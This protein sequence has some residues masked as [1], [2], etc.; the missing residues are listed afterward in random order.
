[1]N[2]KSTSRLAFLAAILGSSVA[3]NAIMTLNFTNVFAGDTPIGNNPWATLT[4]QND[5]SEVKT[6]H[7]Q[8]VTLDKVKFTLS[9]SASSDSTEY[10]TSLFL[11]MSSMPANFSTDTPWTPGIETGSASSGS[12]AFNNNGEKFDYKVNFKSSGSGQ[13]NPG[14]TVSW[15]AKG[16]GLDESM[17]QTSAKP[18]GNKPD[19]IVALL[20]VNHIKIS[21]KPGDGGDDEHDHNFNND[22]RFTG[23]DG[24]DKEHCYGDGHGNGKGNNDGGDCGQGVGSSTLFTSAAAVPEPSSMVAILIGG[25][26]ALRRRKK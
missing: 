15:D 5:G 23:L 13:V 20:D 10:L 6:I 12:N 18:V 17:F 3:A 7:H 16:V 8:Q 4:I 24:G 26:A 11:N 25:I 21:K 14:D 1:M 2:L 9:F 22:L 19:G